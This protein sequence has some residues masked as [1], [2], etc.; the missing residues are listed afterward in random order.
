[1]ERFPKAEFVPQARDRAAQALVRAGRHDDAIAEWKRFLA[2][3]ATH[4]LWKSVRAN[5]VTTAFAKGAALEARDDVGA[6]IEA[7]RAFAEAHEDDPRAPRALHL[8]ARELRERKDHEA[9]LTLLGAIAGRYASTGHAPA[10]RLLAALILEDDLKRLD[11]AIREY[12]ELIKKHPRTRQAS[13]ARQR[14]ERLKR[15]HLEVRMDRVLGAGADPVL[16]VETRNIEKLRVRVYRLGLEEYFQRKGTLQGVENLQLEIVKP[17]WT[18]EWTIDGYAA[19]RLIQ[20]DRK[21]PISE[22]G[23][24]VVVAGDDDLTSTTLFLRSDLEI[25]VKKSEGKQLLVW[26]FDRATHKPVAGA[27]VLAAGQGEVGKT[28]K[29]GV[30]IGTGKK[31]GIRARNVLV[32]SDQGAASTEIEAGRSVASGFRSKA[33]VYTDRPV[34]RPGAEVSWR[35]IF[36]QAYSGSYVAP[37]KRN[38]RVRVY[39]ARGQQVSETKVSSSDFGTFAGTFRVDGAAP[40]GTWR[41]Q[42]IVDKRGTWEGRF[43]VQEFRKP[44]FTIKLKPAKRVYL[45]GETLEATIELKYAFGG[46]VA[47]APVRYDVFRQPKVFEASAAEDYSWYFRDDPAAREAAS[48]PAAPP[49][50][51]MPSATRIATGEVRT[52]GQ[53][54]AEITIE[55]QERDDDAEYIVRASAMDVTRRWIQAQDRI[56]VTRADHM[57]V[58]K[59]DRKVY[60]PKQPVLARVRTMDARER[61]VSRSGTLHLVRV[62][63][64]FQ[65]VKPGSYPPAPPMVS[66]AR[67]WD[68]RYVN[69]EEVEVQ[70]FRVTTDASGEAELRLTLDEPGRYRLRWRSKSRGELVT[71]WANLEASGEAEDLSKDARLTSAK[72]LHKEGE[73]AEVLLNSPMSRGKALLTYEG[74]MVLDY[75]FVE[76]TS[77]STLL[78][79]PLE[80][81]HAP[82]V[83]FKVAIPGKEKL[84]EAQTEVIVLRHLDVEVDV[85]P[86]TALPGSEVEVSLTAK[87]ANGKPV[88]A[89]LGLALVDETV[90]AVARDQAPAIRPYFYDKRRVNVVVS[91]SS[92]GTRFYGTTRETSK[93]LLAD[94]AAR[95]GDAKR[96]YARSAV[97]LAREALRRGDVEAGLRQLVLAMKADPQ[98]WDAR[99]MLAELRLKAE[100]DKSFRVAF[101]R[102]AGAKAEAPAEA[103][104]MAD[105]EMGDEDAAFDG[106]N[107]DRRRS[108]G[109]WAD[110]FAAEKKVGAPQPAPTSPKI[111]LGGGAGGAF[112]GRAGGRPAKPGAPA[113]VRAGASIEQLQRARLDAARDQAGLAMLHE[114]L[115]K[116]GAAPDMQS[117]G[118]MLAKLKETQG[119]FGFD[120]SGGFEV[121]KEFADTAAWKPGVRTGKD[122]TARVKVKLP[123]NLTTWRATVRG[124]SKSALV[125]AGRGSVVARR[126]LLVRIDPPRFLTQGDELTIATAVHNNTGDGVEVTVQVG[127]EGV[128]LSGQDERLSI[129]AGGRAISDRQFASRTPGPVTIEARAGAGP[130]GD[131]VEVKLGAIARGLKVY[132]GRSGSSSTARGAL[133]ETFVD[134]PENVIP[135]TNRL[136]VM[137]YPG[138]SDA[139]LDALLYLDLYPYGCVEQTVHRFLPALQAQA[140]LTG[141]GHLAADRIEAL[142]KAAERGALRLRNLQNP[143]GSFGWFRGG[144][145]LRMT[146]YALRG[147]VAARAA[148]IQ[149]L[150]RS[151]TMARGALMRLV[152]RGGEDARA[153]AHLAL[154]EAGTVHRE[155]YATT[156]R[157]RNEDLSVAGLGYLALAAHR[158]KRGF[159]GE[160]L[161]RLLLERRVEEGLETHWKARKGDCF[162]GSDVEATGLAVE[163]LLA[164]R[165]AGPHAK[166]G[167]DWLLGHRVKGGMGT[168]KAAAAFVGAAARW[169]QVGAVQGFGGTVEVLLDGKVVRTVSTFEKLELGDRRFTLDEAKDLAT[170]RHRV[171]FRLQGQGD[172]R[173]AVRLESVI[174]SK[175]LPGETHGITL[176]RRYLDP[177]EAPLPGQPAK[178][179]PGYTILREAQRPKIEPQDLDTVGSGDRVLVRLE[180]TAP[181][182]LEYVLVE[183]PLPAGFEVLDATTKGAFAWQERRDNRQVFFLSR[184]KRGK[185]TL[186]YVLQA[187]HLGSFTALGTTAYAMYA[188]EV[189]GRAKGRSIRVLMPDA[190]RAPAA[191]Q[192]ATPDELYA[193]AKRLFG[194]KQWADARRILAALRKEQPL[195]DVIVEEIENLLLRIAIEEKDPRAIVRAREELVR[196]NPR[197]IPGDVDTARAIAFAYETVGEPEVANGLFR[198]LV[199]R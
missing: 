197:R 73:S 66:N 134:V 175:D 57:A 166:R 22:R 54:R 159:D 86:K 198:D 60:R 30:W 100:T 4:P 15:K 81:R 46:A 158:L 61:S 20:A 95:T 195:R 31:Q 194:E 28:G 190:A 141:S 7:W 50:A 85:E 2:A 126:N 13:Q 59:V 47:N 160:E 149:M 130:V 48:F 164:H 123:D 118:A 184:V 133:Q 199:A 178:V 182:D 147:L 33:Y 29:D 170:G 135:G 116:L 32:I 101:S 78:D 68:G 107:A 143:D 173:W 91:A 55:T 35:G 53:G 174:A 25:V 77:G 150:D 21:L 167:M 26:A 113:P 14:I 64:T 36:M 132:D 105:M 139:V 189:H 176:A 140:A 12:E 179:K 70:S 37:E 17:D 109:A 196:R 114:R 112:R 9:A 8:A 169:L 34:Y 155:A 87:D 157:R 142:R 181:R 122:G 168:T 127:A 89:E 42:L 131:A 41:V 163:A 19:H 121:R 72:T 16:R 146:A 82:N 38:G 153:L 76:L 23:A 162:S 165:V 161:V 187:T 27:R 43:E 191:E 63:R 110:K 11:D 183:D 1:V 111:G 192:G 40:L 172:I 56:P 80:G 128:E 92:L 6:A 83:F 193:E 115:A 186:E 98:S 180:L 24:Y 58:V 79:L 10:A 148:G 137:L 90:Y 120:A 45:T 5:I 103:E 124:V 171:G 49:V 3:H 136:T 84:H 108:K 44:E 69:E 94:A 96:V 67:R 65:P 156:F 102:F 104:P 18:S 145:D 138:V 97:R 106:K 125:G 154:A 93:D 119:S 185:V 71:A 129:P 117:R 99:S 151:I 144:G 62:R 39:D 177:E 51:P 188:P 88:E 152:Q 74:E 75:R 52:D